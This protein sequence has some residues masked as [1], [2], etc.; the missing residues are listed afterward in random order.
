LT[1]DNLLEIGWLRRAHGVR[2]QVNVELTSERPERTE[3]GA[4]WWS[5]GHWLTV[6]TAQ[7][8]LGRWLVTF[9]EIT[10]REQA[11]TFTNQVAYAEAL[12]DNGEMWVHELIGA[13]VVETGGTARGRC[14]AV[15]DNPAADLLELESG[16]LV[17]VVFVVEHGDGR[18]LID[19]PPGLFELD[20]D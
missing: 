4:R 12:P 18:I 20:Q 13:E 11:Q 3:P 2:G 6:N 15:I 9:D 19:P 14:V 16:A 1:P 8:H 17:P 7:F 5:N 10:G